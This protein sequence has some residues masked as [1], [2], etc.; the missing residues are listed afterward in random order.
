MASAR[1]IE[2]GAYVVVMRMVHFGEGR[3][4]QTRPLGS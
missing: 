3:V 1:H 2:L 4:T